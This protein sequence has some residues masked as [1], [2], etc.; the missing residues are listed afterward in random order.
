M[1]LTLRFQ[2]TGTVPGS[3]GPVEMVGS[4]LTI[5]RGPDNDL[6]LP[7]P[8]RTISKRHCVLEARGDAVVAIDISSNGTFLNYKK[9]PLGPEPSPLNH[10]DILSI[11]P[12]ELLVEIRAASAPVPSETDFLAGGLAMGAGL[13]PLAPVAA[14]D[15]LDELLPPEP[16][17]ASVTDQAAAPII[18][19]DA[20]DALF[21]PL[22]RPEAEAWS[23]APARPAETAAHFTPAARAEGNLIPEDFDLGLGDPAPTSAQ[24]PEVTPQVAPQV[25]PLPEP[26]RGAPFAK[27]APPEPSP[28]AMSPQPEPEP[29]PPAPAR[30]AYQPPPRAPVPTT[31][32]PLN[33][34]EVAAPDPTPTPTPEGPLAPAASPATQ[35]TDLARRYLAAMGAGEGVVSDPDLPEAMDRMGAIMRLF[36]A[37]IREI[38]MTR[39]AIKGEFRMNQTMIRATGNNPLKFSISEDQAIEAIARPPGKGYLPPEAAV[40]EALTDIKAHEMAMVTGMQAALK[41]LLAQLDPQRLAAKLEA[42]NRGSFFK[43]KKAQ[44]W[45]IYEETYSEIARQAE[46]DFQELFVTEFAKAYQTQLEKLK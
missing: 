10:G 18:P 32:M 34:A 1:A 14:R 9:A 44:Y 22:D 26:S 6:V 27:P 15:P 21:G 24:T 12:Y 17:G 39:T 43:G 31:Q 4:N 38:L 45:E 8:Q 33:R 29:A 36:V 28:P 5:G 19:E 11:G 3:A 7:D 42:S 40:A 46:N 37:G 13:D 2:T 30:P 20:D 41:G 23:P 16:G 25:A 35:G